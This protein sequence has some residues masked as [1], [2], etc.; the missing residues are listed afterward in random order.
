MKLKELSLKTTKVTQVFFTL[1]C[2]AF[3]TTSHQEEIKDLATTDTGLC[4][5]PITNPNGSSEL[6][7]L[8]RNMTKT[9]T[10]LKSEV[11]NGNLPGT[12]PEEFLKIHTAKPTDSETKK[13]NFNVFANNYISALSNFYKSDKS[14]LRLNYSN[15]INACSNCHSEHCPGPLTAINKLKL[16]D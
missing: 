3:C 14:N 12:F 15:V 8:M 7:V 1:T 5:S 9:F 10:S 2:F 16:T 13:E 11:Q 4:V 6:A